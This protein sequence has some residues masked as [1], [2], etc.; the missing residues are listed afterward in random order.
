MA[1]VTY[2]LLWRETMRDLLDML[3]LDPPQDQDE[4]EAFQHFSYLYIK[5]VQIFKNLEDCYDQHVHPQKRIDI[6]DVLEAVIGRMLE[7]KGYLVTLK[8]LKFINFDDILVDL[9]LIPETLE[10]P[11]PRYFVDERQKDLMLREKLV[12]TLIAARDADKDDVAPEGSEKVMSTEDAIKVI[13]IN[14]RGR[15]GKQRARFMKEIRK[16]EELEKKLREMGQPETDPDSAA[17][18]IQKLFRGFKT[19]KQARMMR[20]EELVFIGMKQPEPKPRELDPVA[21]Q[22]D[23]RSRRKIIQAQ[24]KDEYEEALVNIR[25]KIYDDEG[26]DMRE[27]MMD[28]I[29]QWFVLFREHNDSFPEYPEEETGGSIFIFDPP[30]VVEPEEEEEE[31]GGD[32]KKDDKKKD[33]KKDDKKKKGEEEEEDEGPQQLPVSEFVLKMQACTE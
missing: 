24:N 6:K 9:K 14:E 27:Q 29:R 33:D 15:Q 32:K 25:R 21:R 3:E 5:Y 16:Q 10:L 4:E 11:V 22:G 8:G 18:V 13:Q 12:Q 7:I 17:V 23:I 19:M 28:K 26:V 30:P 2:D 1:N 31:G 20:E